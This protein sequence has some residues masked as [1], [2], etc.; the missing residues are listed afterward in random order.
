L[1]EKPLKRIRTKQFQ[2][3]ARGD[4][5]KIALIAAMTAASILRQSLRAIKSRTANI[6]KQTGLYDT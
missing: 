2:K 6:N 4:L 1:K 5:S 3:S